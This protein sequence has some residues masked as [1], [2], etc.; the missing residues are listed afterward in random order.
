MSC[1]TSS[2]IALTGP[3]YRFAA[4]WPWRVRGEARGGEW[5]M[6]VL[7]RLSLISEDDLYLFN[8]G[9]HLHLHEKLGAHP[10]PE[11]TSFAVW[12]P[13][14]EHVSVFGDFNEWNAGAHPLSP[15]GVSGIWEGFIPEARPGQV[16]KYRV[17]GR[18]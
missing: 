8:E 10:S 6:S 9:S 7:S 15:R 14:A 18:G 11:G 12:A 2:T 17:H 3:K 13:N 4:C 16:Y 5:N 1:A